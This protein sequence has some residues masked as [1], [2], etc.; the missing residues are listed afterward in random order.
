MFDK[1]TAV[2][3]CRGT[4]TNASALASIDRLVV[5]CLL[6][7][8]L[9]ATSSSDVSAQ[10]VFSTRDAFLAADSSVVRA[11]LGALSLTKSVALDSIVR[12]DIPV[13]SAFFQLSPDVFWA[14]G[15]GSS[16]HP[17]AGVALDR[18]RLATMREQLDGSDFG[19]VTLFILAHEFAH[20]GQFRNYSL[21][22]L[23]ETSRLKAI[24]CQADLWA[25]AL[26]INL[27]MD[28]AMA[29]AAGRATRPVV[30]AIV[31]EGFARISKALAL[32]YQIGT[33]V[34]DD[35]TTHPLPAKRQLCVARGVNAGIQMRLVRAYEQTG[36]PELLNQISAWR[37][38]DRDLF[39]PG[40]DLWAWTNTQAK[41]IVE[42]EQIGQSPGGRIDLIGGLRRVT[43][44]AEMGP[45]YL[46]SEASPGIPPLE[47]S[48]TDEI[49]AVGLVCKDSSAL[50]AKIQ[51]D[52][53]NN[54]RAI[55]RGVLLPRGWAEQPEQL[56]ANGDT[57]SSAFVW[58]SGRAAVIVFF[59]KTARQWRPVFLTVLS[60]KY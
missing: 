28:S 8:L 10:S 32:A 37:A 30:T 21:A 34:W 59:A 54:Y 36:S 55:A 48:S 17:T 56:S 31:D 44:S 19:D 49:D 51:L 20:M 47:C 7:S 26:M 9:T 43:E 46:R 11:R 3:R 6:F 18:Q 23:R 24:E 4:I 5:A 35:P 60:K 42:N 52:A 50:S 39:G 38:K 57:T 53:Y 12:A 27:M 13:V 58:G 1:S 40:A 33:P 25:G 2:L 16:S 45:D 14:D 41:S 15:Q 22:T 29:R